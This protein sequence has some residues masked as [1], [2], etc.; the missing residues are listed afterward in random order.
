MHKFGCFTHALRIVALF[1]FVAAMV[2]CS[3]HYVSPCPEIKRVLD[4]QATAWNRGDI[5]EFMRYYWRSEE[6][7]FSAGGA[8]QRGWQATYD[9]YK[10]RYP[11]AERM[12]KL[13]FNELHTMPIAGHD[14]AALVL[15][16]WHLERSPDPV[17]GN[18]SLVMVRQNGRWVIVHDHTSANPPASGN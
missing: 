1:A 9:R 3:V 5:D 16:R 15:G 10:S 13:T 17:G 7:T 2:G 14:D 12:G 4:A 18:F 8:T 11:N 6:L